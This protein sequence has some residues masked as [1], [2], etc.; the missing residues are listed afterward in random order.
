MLMAQACPLLLTPAHSL[1]CLQVDV[2]GCE[3][4]VLQGMDASTWAITRQVV[5]EVSLRCT[6]LPSCCCYTG[7]AHPPARGLLLASGCL[8]VPPHPLIQFDTPPVLCL[9]RWQ[10][11]DVGDRLAAVQALLEGQGFALQAEQQQEGP[12]GNW[13]VFAR[14]AS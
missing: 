13:L 12:D 3:L 5:A 7:V 6:A 10:V 9:C 8:L 1:L 14:R 11:H 2:E 4:D